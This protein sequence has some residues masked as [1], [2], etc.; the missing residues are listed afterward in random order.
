MTNLKKLFKN[1]L[2]SARSGAFFNAFSYPTKISPESIAVYIASITKPGD[3]VLDAFGGS[4]S[5]GLAALLCE[6]PTD[7]M[8]AI[9]KKIGVNPRTL[10]D[11]I[12]AFR[13]F[14]GGFINIT[15]AAKEPNKLVTNYGMEM[16]VL[17]PEQVKK[18]I[19]KLR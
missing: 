19:W 6:H 14:D 17:E 4:G 8:K 2:P 9:A 18:E 1:P 16:E 15:E 12:R 11:W 13:S 5:T 7:N 10:R 3:T